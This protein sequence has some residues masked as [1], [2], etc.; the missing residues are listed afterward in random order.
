M[1]EDI[2]VPATDADP[3]ATTPAPAP[4]PTPTVPPPAA[5]PAPVAP[6][7]PANTSLIGMQY[8]SLDEDDIARR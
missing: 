6:L 3:G 2:A 1:S 8:R 4:D 5:E 7:P